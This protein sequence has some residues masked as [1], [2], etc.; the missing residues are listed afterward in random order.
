LGMY[1]V[2]QVLFLVLV[3]VRLVYALT[4]AIGSMHN[5]RARGRGRGDVCRAKF[6]PAVP[7]IHR[8]YA[9]RGFL[10]AIFR[11]PFK[12]RAEITPNP[13]PPCALHA[14]ARKAQGGTPDARCQSGG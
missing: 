3:L 12:T 1:V 2:S 4:H 5:A 13:N 9:P 14:H 6:I 8:N 11:F 7:H 10:V